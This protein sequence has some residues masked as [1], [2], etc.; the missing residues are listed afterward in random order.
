MTIAGDAH[1]F[2]VIFLLPNFGTTLANTPREYFA[3]FRSDV[4][5]STMRTPRVVTLVPSAL[6]VA[7]DAFESVE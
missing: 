7:H 6:F 5:H 2:A 3:V 4:V 1:F